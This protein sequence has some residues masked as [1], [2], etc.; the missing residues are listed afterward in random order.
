MWTNRL[1]CG[2][3]PVGFRYQV[4][5]FISKCIVIPSTIQL[6]VP[7]IATSFTKG[8]GN[9]RRRLGWVTLGEIKIWKGWMK[10]T[11]IREMWCRIESRARERS[12]NF[13]PG[14]LRWDFIAIAKWMTDFRWRI[15]G[16]GP[17][18]VHWCGV[19]VAFLHDRGSAND[20]YCHCPWRPYK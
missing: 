17:N 1:I 8:S 2:M 13:G 19:Y 20:W 16:C 15:C 18:V 10:D 14:L 4:R 5:R 9:G 6:Q 3:F 12:C 7:L 11:R